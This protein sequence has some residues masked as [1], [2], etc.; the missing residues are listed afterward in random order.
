MKLLNK[1]K[2]IL[3]S[4]LN[5][6]YFFVFLISFIITELGREFYRPYIYINDIN[7]FGLADTV[8][9]TFGSI[10]LIFLILTLVINKSFRKEHLLIP[11]L[12]IILLIYEFL[13]KYLPGYRLDWKDVVSTIVAGV[14]SYFIYRLIDKMTEK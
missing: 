11:G 10:T 13:Q 3:R 9:N 1:A 14:I 12:V 7:D 2:S 6:L 8:G 4:K 5:R